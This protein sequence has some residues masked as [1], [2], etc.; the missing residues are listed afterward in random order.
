[1][2]GQMIIINLD[3][4]IPKIREERLSCRT[5]CASLEAGIWKQRDQTGK[6]KLFTVWSSGK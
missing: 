2:R 4:V 5:A 1:M 6:Q 3:C